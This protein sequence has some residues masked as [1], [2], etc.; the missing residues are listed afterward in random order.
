M[1]AR[2]SAQVTAPGM[3]GS[4]SHL[5]QHLQ[6]LEVR[7]HDSQV[8][9][10]AVQL[11]ALLHEDFLEFGRSGGVHGRADT[12]DSLG[13]ASEPLHLVSD[14]FALVRL[15]PDSA[16][17]TY[18]SAS[19]AEDGT[20]GRLTLRSSVWLRT[21]QGWQMRFHQGTPTQPFDLAAPSP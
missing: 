10:D 8:R 19:V 7:L 20:A 15:G 16:L 4:D 11:Q 3:N 1:G 2:V 5:L 9:S 14:S 18:R 13:A 17:L 6:A 21:G 12:V